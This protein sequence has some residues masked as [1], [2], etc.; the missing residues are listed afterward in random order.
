MQQVKS[1]CRRQ[2]RRGQQAYSILPP[3]KPQLPQ[4]AQQRPNSS[5]PRPHPPNTRSPLCT[6]CGQPKS[7]LN[8]I[9]PTR[10]RSREVLMH[11]LSNKC[12]P[13]ANQV[14]TTPPQDLGASP[15]VC[16][17]SKGLLLCTCVHTGAQWH[18]VA[19]PPE[20][21]AASRCRK[22]RRHLQ[23][24]PREQ[25]MRPAAGDLIICFATTFAYAVLVFAYFVLSH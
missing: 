12:P 17:P 21:V 24:R 25:P 22:A 20:A 4:K 8:R 3:T 13:R 5:Q 14:S 9:V 23:Q 10:P 6:M 15:P 1:P 19:R 2:E 7:T 16:N 18:H 11:A